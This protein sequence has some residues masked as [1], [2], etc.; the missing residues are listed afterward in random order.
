MNCD[1]C[2]HEL[3]LQEQINYLQKQLEEIETK[4]KKFEENINCKFAFLSGY[5]N[6]SFLGK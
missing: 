6:I 2:N 5:L 4:N 3:T 1:K